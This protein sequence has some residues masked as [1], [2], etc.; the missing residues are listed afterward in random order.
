VALLEAGGPEPTGAQYPGSY[1]TYSKPPKESKINWN[2]ETEPQQNACLGKPRGRCIYPR[3]MPYIV[4]TVK[5][6]LSGL[7]RKKRNSDK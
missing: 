6:S 1:F 3:G 7:I 5:L 4:I 2:F